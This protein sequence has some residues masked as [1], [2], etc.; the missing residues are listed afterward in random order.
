MAEVRV[1]ELLP[2]TCEW[3]ECSNPAGYQWEEH[4]WPS[5]GWMPFISYRCWNHS[6][7]YTAA[8]P[9]EVYSLK[10]NKR[11]LHSYDAFIQGY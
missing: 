6:K 4:S 5:I 1:K 9:Y 10:T 7:Y 2:S 8:P 11:I 3:P